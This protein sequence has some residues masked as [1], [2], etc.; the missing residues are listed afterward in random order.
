MDECR[1]VDD[2]VLLERDPEKEPQRRYGVIE[3]GRMY[4]VL[5]K[6]QLKAPDIFE[7]GRLG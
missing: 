5:G 3:N 6:M 7:A 1:V 4:A 2:V